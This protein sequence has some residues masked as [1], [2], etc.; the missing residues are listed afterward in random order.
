[1]NRCVRE[2]KEERAREAVFSVNRIISDRKTDGGKD[3]Q[4]QL[5][6]ILEEAEKQLKGTRLPRKWRKKSE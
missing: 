4:K 6:T 1:M 5:M 3:M 2:E